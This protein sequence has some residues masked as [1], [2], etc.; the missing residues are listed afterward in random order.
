MSQR[1]IVTTPSL[2]KVDDSFDDPRFMKVRIKA[3]HSDSNLNKSNFTESSLKKSKDLWTYSA[4][5]ANT[6]TAID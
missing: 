5:L 2:F 1:H 6:I 3:L 4:I